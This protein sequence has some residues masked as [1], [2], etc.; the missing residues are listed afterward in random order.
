MFNFRIV[1]VIADWKRAK[2]VVTSNC[3]IFWKRWV[4]FVWEL[5]GWI[6]SRLLI[7]VSANREIILWEFLWTISRFSTVN[8]PS[9]PGLGRSRFVTVVCSLLANLRL[10]QNETWDWQS[11]VSTSYIYSCL[12]SDVPAVG[13]K[14][15]PEWLR[16]R[17]KSRASDGGGER[18]TWWEYESV[19]DAIEPTVLSRV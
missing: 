2:R 18:E 17:T 6:Q 15:T 16:R 3:E 9:L 12:S 4:S 19:N 5:L 14:V 10:P 11:D 7:S 1:D 13:V 8:P